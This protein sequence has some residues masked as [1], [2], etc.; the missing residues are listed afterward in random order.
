VKANF[1]AGCRYRVRLR[2]PK[3]ISPQ[4]VL[5]ALKNELCDVLL[6]TMTK[7]VVTIEATSRVT[8]TLDSEF[9]LEV[10]CLPA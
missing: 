2:V 10:T 8:R 9:L 5:V 7:G 1:R 4:T 6:G 3:L